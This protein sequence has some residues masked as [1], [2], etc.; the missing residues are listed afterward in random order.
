MLE[1]VLDAADA[2]GHEGEAGAIEDGFLHPG[3]EAEAQVLADLAD[4]PEEVQVEKVS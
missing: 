4:L 3:D 1:A 2:V